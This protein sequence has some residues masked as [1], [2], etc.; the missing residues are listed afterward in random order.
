MKRITCKIC[1]KRRKPWWH[2]WKKADAIGNWHKDDNFI[3]YI[4]VRPL[5]VKLCTECVNKRLNYM[6]HISA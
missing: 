2:T 3:I 4:K 5:S 6:V 1:G